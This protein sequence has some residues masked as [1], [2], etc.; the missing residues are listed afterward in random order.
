MRS[1]EQ[2]VLVAWLRRP[3][4]VWSTVTEQLEKYGSV[5]AAAAD[6]SPA[7]GTLFDVAAVDDDVQAAV[8]DLER[9]GR[10][11]IRNTKR[12]RIPGGM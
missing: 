6:D 5:Q 7:Q 9:W 4:V 3:K 12:F 1:E 11:G 8:A 2:A 10:A